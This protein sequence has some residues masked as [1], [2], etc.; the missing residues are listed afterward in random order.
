[1]SDDG[2]EVSDEERLAVARE[3]RVPTGF[4]TVDAARLWDA[5]VLARRDLAA[6]RE[7]AD[8]LENELAKALRRM[9]ERSEGG[10]TE[11]SGDE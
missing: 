3:L 1:M 6:E 5:L 4:P 10:H 7:R 9:C 8:G 2:R 11:E